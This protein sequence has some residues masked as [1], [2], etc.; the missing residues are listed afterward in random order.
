M[1]D[2]TAEEM[3]DVCLAQAV[4]CKVFTQAQAAGDDVDWAGALKDID[5]AKLAQFIM[6]FILMFI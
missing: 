2:E 1:D 3:A 5:W 6:P 4:E